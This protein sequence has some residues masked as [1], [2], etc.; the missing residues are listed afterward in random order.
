MTN[1]VIFS[2]IKTRWSAT[3]SFVYL[4]LNTE[5]TSQL[6]TSKYS[7]I[8]ASLQESQNIKICILVNPQKKN[9][10]AY[11]Q[12]LLYMKEIISIGNVYFSFFCTKMLLHQSQ[13]YV[14]PSFRH[15]TVDILLF[16][17][18]NVHYIISHSSIYLKRCV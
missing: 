1:H 7:T 13:M 10:R 14:F 17:I 16:Y 2:F 9:S 15:M 4:S 12:Q 8:F 18:Q 11:I 6:V 5:W 3:Y